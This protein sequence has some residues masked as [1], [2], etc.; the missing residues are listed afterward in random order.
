MPFSS[1]SYSLPALNPVVTATAI[2]S[3]WANNTMSDIATALST[4]MLKD[5]TQTITANI[6]MAGFKFTGLGTGSA[7]GNSLRY[8]QLFAA[9]ALNL[10]GP[11]NWVK[12]TVASATSPDIWTSAGNQIDY[13]GTVTATSFATAPQAGAMRQLVCAGAAIFTA[14]ANMLIQGVPSGSNYTAVAGDVIT[15]IAIT[16]SQF[17]LFID[18]VTGIPGKQPT[19]QVFTSGS[20]ATYT[21]PAGA[22]RINVRMVGGGGGGAAA[23]TNSGIDGNNTTFSTLTAS[24]GIKGITSAGAGG[25][26][27]AAS[28]GDINIPGGNGSGG[29]A[30]ATVGVGPPAGGGGASAFGGGGGGGASGAAGQNAAANSGGGGGGGA[31]GSTTAS[32]GGGGAGG[33]VEKLILAP[34]AT[35]TYTVG[36]AVNGGAAGVFAGGNGAAG[37]IIVDEWYN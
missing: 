31:G 36:A 19:R 20:G 3:T 17:R 6:P 12:T 14:G 26:G 25:A 35:Y 15:V 30:S 24:G 27:G 9:A 8:E 23:T 32:G 11:V 5:G 22:V 28:G 13:T 21:T 10:L 34:S 29:G 37:I 18:P 7:A 1:G 16:T 4:A 2:S 33:Y